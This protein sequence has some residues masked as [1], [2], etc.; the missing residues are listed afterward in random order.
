MEDTAAGASQLVR[1]GLAGIGQQLLAKQSRYMADR[2][3]ERELPER[4]EP[5]LNVLF[6][7]RPLANVG[8]MTS[9]EAHSN[10]RPPIG[11]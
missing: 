4:A 3:A 7:D 8:E 6:E 11:E 10:A 5:A 1:P 9:E 2:L